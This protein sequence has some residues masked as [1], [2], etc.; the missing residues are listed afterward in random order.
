MTA[1]AILILLVHLVWI[2]LMIFGAFWT[3]G[4]PGWTTI[5][6]LSLLWGIVAEAGPWPCPLTL[7]EEYFEN[8][9][10]LAAYHGSFLLHTL[11]AV[12]YPN[13]PSW[14]V[15]LIGVTVCVF[16]L[17]IYVARFRKYVLHRVSS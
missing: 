7:A 8:L 5:H 13:L 2:A 16:N 17:G 1:I 4:R 6:V 14:A 11:D 9:A 12:V 3:R 10:G 15:T